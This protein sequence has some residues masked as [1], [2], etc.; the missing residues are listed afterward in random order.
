MRVALITEGGYPYRSG[1]GSGWCRQLITGLDSHTFHVVALTD[2]DPGPPANSN[3]PRNLIEVLPT[4]VWG[5]P[6]AAPGWFTRRRIRRAATTAA[7]LVCQGMLGGP[8]QASMFRDGLVRLARLSAGGVH[9]LTGVPLA[10]VLAAH[11]RAAAAQPPL[12][13]A[14]AHIAAVMLEHALRPLAVPAPTA[15]LTHPTASGLGLLVALAA[16]WRAGIPYLLTELGIYLRQ[17]YLDYR[18]RLPPAVRTV[19]L[20]FFRALAELGYTEATVVAAGSRFTQR[21]QVR[22]G[23]HPGKVVVV[24]GGADPAEF[25]IRPEP[26]EPNVVWVGR[27]GPLQDLGT[28]LEA[29]H[30]VRWHLP[31]AR[32]RLVGP[33]A[34]PDYQARC[35]QQIRQ[36]GLTDAVEFTGELPHPAPA[37]AAGQVVVRSGVGEGVPY[38]V[39]EAMMSGRATVSTDVGATAELVG[40]TGLLV[41]AGDPAALAGSLVTLLTDPVRRRTLATAAARRAREAFPVDLMLRA[42]QHLYQDVADRSPTGPPVLAREGGPR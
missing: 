9:P 5:P 3:R 14:D 4:P 10:R 38:P 40:E 31:T 36:L 41:P 12:S 1:S 16:K 42:Y 29:F 7:A 18:D 26:A 37:Y 28:L 2:A 21:W 20:C 19:M 39:L 23:A 13:S 8:E 6:A 17:R 34:D 25:P 27:I 22:H 11:W 32:L 24:P 35:Q 33:T 15:D 30:R